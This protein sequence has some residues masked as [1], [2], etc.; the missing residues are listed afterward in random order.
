MSN[1][2][3]RKRFLDFFHEDEDG[4]VRCR[5][6]EYRLFKGTA[7]VLP[8]TVCSAFGFDPEGGLAIC[9]LTSS[10]WV[11]DQ[12]MYEVDETCSY[13]AMGC[14][15][16]EDTTEQ[17]ENTAEKPASSELIDLLEDSEDSG[18]PPKTPVVNLTSPDS[19]PATPVYNSPSSDIKTPVINLAE[20]DA[21]RFADAFPEG[22]FFTDKVPVDVDG[23]VT[24]GTHKPDGCEKDSRG[25]SL[26]SL[27]FSKLI[28]R[29]VMQRGGHLR[30]SP[31]SG[32]R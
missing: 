21:F 32:P 8:E 6:V 31:T 23:D 16:D 28:E 20:S 5:P 4:K 25:G 30:Q 22:T 12:E 10:S 27:P 18:S 11:C 14:F 29:G 13:R 1:S 17:A 26:V 7:Y 2:N 9:E 24:Y 15:P 19:N 3:S